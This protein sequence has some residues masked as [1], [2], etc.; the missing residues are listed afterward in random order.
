MK[1]K[2]EFDF[3]EHWS[4]LSDDPYPHKKLCRHVLKELSYARAEYTYIFGILSVYVIVDNLLDDTKE[5]DYLSWL[6]E[7]ISSLL[8][9]AS[10]M[11][12]S[13]RVCP[14]SLRYRRKLDSLIKRLERDLDCVV[15]LLNTVVTDVDMLNTVVVGEDY[16]AP[17]DIAV[18]PHRTPLYFRWQ[19]N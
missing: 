3:R 6:E 13:Y 14:Y 4:M 8:R 18:V 10:A 5:D 17:S 15:V 7:E 11:W 2:K 12:D 9:I 1:K 16:I 19:R